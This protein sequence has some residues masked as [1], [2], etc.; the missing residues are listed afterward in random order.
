[1][2]TEPTTADTKKEPAKGKRISG[3]KIPKKTKRLAPQVRRGSKIQE[4]SWEG[5]LTWDGKTF[6]LARRRASE[7]YYEHFKNS[8]IEPHLYSWMKENNY[9]MT[10]IKAA[11]AAPASAFSGTACYL[12]RMLMNGMPDLHEAH[13]KFWE[14]LP[15]T[16]GTMKPVSEF[17]HKKVK[18]LIEVGTPLVQRKELEEKALAAQGQAVPYKPT[19]QDRLNEKFSEIVG[20]LEGWYDEVMLGNDTD[21]KVYEFLTTSTTPQAMVGKISAVYENYK[22]ELLEAQAGTDEQLKEGYSHMKARDFKRHYAFLDKVIDDCDRYAQTKKITRKVRTKKAPSKEKLVAKLKFAKDFAQLKLVSIDP[23]DILNAQELWVYNTK[24]RKLGKYIVGQYSGGLGVKGASLVGFDE[25]KSV[26][27]TL[28]KPDQQLGE[29]MKS[30]KVQLR[31]FLENIK[32][33]ET[34]M[35]G[36]IN[37]DT[38]LLK[39]VSA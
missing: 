17:L 23:V 35:N 27:K 3:I 37:I 9:D 22:A 30:T 1:M 13:A 29:F 19:I 36:R 16:M 32:A 11:K 21:P 39:A 10:A 4:P 12:A 2:A 25:V 8:D 7:F 5:S 24:T 6:H 18:E 14:E 26:A 31:K 34:R 28:R 33:T 38:V 20:E 15:G